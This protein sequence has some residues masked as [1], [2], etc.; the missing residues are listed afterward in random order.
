MNIL[1]A[2]HH[3]RRT[4]GTENY[5]YALIV[6]LLR[7][8][9]HVEYFTYRK[10]YVSSKIESLGV[11]F[12]SKKKY[13]LILANHTTTIQ[14]LHRRGFIIQTC[15]GT[16][17]TLEQPSR[18]ADAHVSVTKEVYKHLKKKGVESALIRNGI[19]C[20]RF[21]PSRPLNT[22]LTSVLSLCQSDEAN[23][24][25]E[26]VCQ[27]N[28]L[29]FLSADKKMDNVW[30][31]EK[32][33]NEADLVVGI[34]RSLYDAMAC[35]RTVVS[36]DMRKYSKALGDGYLDTSNI[37]ESIKHNCSGRGTG[38]KMNEALFESEL[39]KYNPSDGL[40]LR[41]YAMQQ[42][43]IRHSVQQYLA[44]VG[45]QRSVLKPEPRHFISPLLIYRAKLNQLPSFSARA[46][47]KWLVR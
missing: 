41:A 10:G 26:S 12:R 28:Q 8:G 5:T 2:N 4:G 3:L 45:I 42:L 32:L 16:L 33:I 36:F 15:H 38:K 18:Y 11:R 40:F 24:M 34:G 35:G 17:P 14:M 31:L 25:I 22:S 47:L 21:A 27:R 7:L 1:V 20:Q 9:H 6:E 39:R 13:D 37:E 43:N 46:L 23:A 19:D 29:T 30:H 44:L